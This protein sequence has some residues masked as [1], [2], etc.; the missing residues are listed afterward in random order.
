MGS[1]KSLL[2]ALSYSIILDPKFKSIVEIACLI[3]KAIYDFR[4]SDDSNNEYEEIRF[5][6]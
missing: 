2:S 4:Y 6:S 5:N 1:L 3:S